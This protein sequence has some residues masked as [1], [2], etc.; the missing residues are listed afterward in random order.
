MPRRL[1]NQPPLPHTPR[2]RSIFL[3]PTSNNLS[4]AKN[5][6]FANTPPVS[7]LNSPQS[8]RKAHLTAEHLGCR[9]APLAPQGLIREC[10][11]WEFAASSGAGRGEV[12]LETPRAQA[13]SVEWAGGGV[14]VDCGIGLDGCGK[15]WSDRAEGNGLAEGMDAVAGADFAD[16]ADFVG[17]R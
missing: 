16:F 5:L 17:F 6:T 11:S 14:F 9:R 13:R 8:A 12:L 2:P 1:I 15:G 4:L 3:P 10:E 7:A